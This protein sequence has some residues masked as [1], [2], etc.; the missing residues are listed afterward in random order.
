MAQVKS[1]CALR[2]QVKSEELRVKSSVLVFEGA[3]RAFPQRRKTRDE[4]RNKRFACT[5][6]LVPEVWRASPSSIRNAISPP[7]RYGLWDDRK[8]LI[9]NILR[10]IQNNISFI[11]KQCLLV[12]LHLT[13]DLFCSPIPLV[14]KRSKRK[15][16]RAYSTISTERL[17]I[18]ESNGRE[19]VIYTRRTQ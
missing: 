5:S 15:H 2:A 18:W 9:I 13:P 1:I 17:V 16:E 10:H 19:G 8:A 7:Q 14:G 4:W 12:F 3:R 6:Y 11:T